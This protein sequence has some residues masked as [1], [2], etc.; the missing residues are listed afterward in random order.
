MNH[1]FHV[2]LHQ[3]TEK[4]PSQRIRQTSKKAVRNRREINR[5]KKKLRE[6]VDENNQIQKEKIK[7]LQEIIVFF[8]DNKSE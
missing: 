1:C 6:S 8:K 5:I 4:N 7:I 2:R 3:L